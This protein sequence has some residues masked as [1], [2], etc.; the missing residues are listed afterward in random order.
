[1]IIN[2]LYIFFLI[3]LPYVCFA[4]CLFGFYYRFC[5]LCKTYKQNGYCFAEVK[6]GSNIVIA[7]VITLI[8]IH[9]LGYFAV[10]FIFSF[11]N[12]SLDSIKSTSKI[13]QAI[14]TIFALTFVTVYIFYKHRKKVNVFSN[15]FNNLTAMVVIL[16]TALGYLGIMLINNTQ[17]SVEKKL[18]LSSYF[19]GLIS[20]DITTYNYLL[21]VHYTTSLHLVL[22]YMLIGFLSYSTLFDKLHMFILSKVFKKSSA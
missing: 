2:S 3:L 9:V 8:A 21:N 12:L 19:K 16:H 4:S 1:M 11:L 15:I 20:F 18:M 17:N 5:G 14:V 22:G 7:G 10:K 6:S 13:I